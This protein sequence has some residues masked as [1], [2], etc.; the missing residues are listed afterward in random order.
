MSVWVRT[1]TVAFDYVVCRPP[2]VFFFS[3]QRRTHSRLTQ[4]VSS[5]GTSFVSTFS[6]LLTLNCRN[7]FHERSLALSFCLG[8]QTL[9]SYL[10]KDIFLL[11]VLSVCQLYVLLQKWRKS[12]RFSCR[13]DRTLT[14]RSLL[15]HRAICRLL[16]WGAP[17]KWRLGTRWWRPGST[18]GGRC[19]VSLCYILGRN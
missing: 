1:S 11:S 16:W 2:A 6:Y 19:R 4:E 17:R 9:T 12:C 14:A 3:F 8:V 18:P 10:N 13:C 7:V 5:V 15:L